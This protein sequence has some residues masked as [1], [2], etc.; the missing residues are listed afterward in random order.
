MRNKCLVATVVLSSLFGVSAASGDERP[1]CYTVASVRGSWS[2]IGTFGANV[3]KS[4]GVR[5]VDENGNFTGI[6]VLNAPTTGS[7]TGQ[8]TITTGTQT[9]FF[10]VNCDGTG[11][12]T[13]IVTASNGTTANQIDDFVITGSMERGEKLFA[14]SISEAQRPPSA[15]VPGGIFVTRVHTRVHD[16]NEREREQ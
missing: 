1:E 13:R 16:R 14:T 15:L 10:T 12:I 11:T 7:T 8:R 3:A 5:D 6:F 2:V 4:L 9:G